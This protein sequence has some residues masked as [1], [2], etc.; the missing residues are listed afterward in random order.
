MC[1]L[2]FSASADEE[3]DHQCVVVQN[4]FVNVVVSTSIATRSSLRQIQSDSC[5]F[6]QGSA[7]ST[8]TISECTLISSQTDDS[9]LS[10]EASAGESQPHEGEE[11]SQSE[12]LG[13]LG[14]EVS[15][16]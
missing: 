10:T 9:D 3:I 2:P 13:E 1:N 7:C 6:R 11:D 16:V 14:E 5:L 8:R 4:T 15:P 12:G